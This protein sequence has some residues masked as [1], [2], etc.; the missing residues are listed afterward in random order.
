[1]KLLQ[2]APQPGRANHTKRDST[3]F[4][5]QWWLGQSKEKCV[6]EAATVEPENPYSTR[7]HEFSSKVV[8]STE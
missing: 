1:M 3:S 8:A 6:R 5:V 2:Q 4:L 7:Q